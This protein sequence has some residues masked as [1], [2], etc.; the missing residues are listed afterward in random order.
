MANCDIVKKK[1]KVVEL[2]SRNAPAEGV[3]FLYFFLYPAFGTVPEGSKERDSMP[4]GCSRT[5]SHLFEVPEADGEYVK[6]LED[7]KSAAALLRKV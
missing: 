5:G 7:S 2:K 4:D 1:L 6:D 3:D